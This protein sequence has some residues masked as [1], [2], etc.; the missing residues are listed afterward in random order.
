MSPTSYRAAP[1]R[2]DLRSVPDTSEP[3]NKT[4]TL[5]PFPSHVAI[6]RVGAGAAGRNERGPGKPTTGTRGRLAPSR[7]EVKARRAR[8]AKR[9]RRSALADDAVGLHRLESTGSHDPP[10]HP[11]RPARGEEPVGL[12]PER[13]PELRLQGRAGNVDSTGKVRR[14]AL[15]QIL[16]DDAAHPYGQ[17]ERDRG[18]RD[19]EQEP[20][21]VIREPV[22]EVPA[23]EAER[24]IH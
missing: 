24:R 2:D 19:A 23:E 11:P 4:A 15:D 6:A 13:P 9:E 1:P 21:R 20:D 12:A 5:S 8:T 22:R 3:V 17:P 7:G 10:E 18:K 14:E 16:R